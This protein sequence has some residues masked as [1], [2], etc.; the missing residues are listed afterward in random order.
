MIIISYRNQ[1]KKG[2][3]IKVNT[4]RKIFEN[5]SMPLDKKFKYKSHLSTKIIEGME[6][7]TNLNR[8]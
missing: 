2:E 1:D 6:Y 7:L 4:K 3:E 5:N 8:E